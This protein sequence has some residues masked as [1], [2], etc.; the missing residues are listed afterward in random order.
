MTKVTVVEIEGCMASSAAI[1]HDVMATANRISGAKRA[2]PFE[3]TRVRC[4]PRRN[5]TELHGTE[6]VIL[7]GLGTASADELDGKL[8]SPACRRASDMLVEA[9]EAGEEFRHGGVHSG[10]CHAADGKG[11]ESDVGELKE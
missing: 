3:V 11:V 10:R 7:P 9:F 8:K 6:L 5:R 4:G 2:L 1:T